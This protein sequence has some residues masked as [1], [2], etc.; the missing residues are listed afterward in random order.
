LTEA[1]VTWLKDSEPEVRMAGIETLADYLNW[2]PKNAEPLVAMMRDEDAR[3][4]HAAFF[5][6][7]R[8]R[9]DLE[10]FA[11]DF[12]EMLKDKDP[13]IQ[14]AGLQIL[15]RFDMVI[16]REDLLRFFNSSDPETVSWAFTQ[17]VRQDEKISAD[18]AMVLLQNSQP[19]ARQL[20]LRALDRNPEKQSVELALPLLRDPDEIVRLK[21]TQ[22]LRALTGQ[23]FTEDQADEWAK[24]WTKNKTNFVVRSHPEESRALPGGRAY[25]DRGCGYYD[26]HN[27]VGSLADFRNACELGSEVQ[28]YSYYRIWLIRAR[29]GEKE[30]ATQELVS[31]LNNRKA[32]NPTDWPLQVG[33]FLAGQITEADFL[34]AAADA[35]TKADREQHCEAYFYAGSKRL[36]ENDK[37]GAADF[38]KK[39]LGT[40][41]T[42]FEEY[43]SAEAEL[44][45]LH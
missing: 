22:T 32:Q 11:P 42:T 13:G 12:R 3:V 21:A 7:P 14:S 26:M 1:A 18:E 4:R 33:R 5:T 10:R 8:F 36:I 25:H 39:C 44:R 24:W 41:V 27:F 17:M 15:Q 38:F 45:V 34:K 40:G 2:N 16:P 29:S 43:H 20:G 30:A 6:L 19:L 23:Q 9:G 28:D 31:Y 37:T 35:N